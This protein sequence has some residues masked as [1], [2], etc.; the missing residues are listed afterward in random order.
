VNQRTIKYS[1]NQRYRYANRDTSTQKASRR[2]RTDRELR[3]HHW[4]DDFVSQWFRRCGESH[5][6]IDTTSQ[7]L[8]LDKDLKRQAI[9]RLSLPI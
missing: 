6:D 2:G 3:V 5:S 9:N 1:H 7:Y 8:N 4:G